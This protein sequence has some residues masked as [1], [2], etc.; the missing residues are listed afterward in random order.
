MRA[1]AFAA[2]F[3]QSPDQEHGKIPLIKFSFSQ[4]RDLTKNA[5]Y[6]AKETR[7]GAK[8]RQTL[9]KIGNKTALKGRDWRQSTLRKFLFR[10][11]AILI[12]LGLIGFIGFAYVGDLSPERSEQVVPTEIELK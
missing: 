2:G 6:K 4:W 12:L 1:T 7:A 3:A 8:P 9:A 5:I 11:L 10:L